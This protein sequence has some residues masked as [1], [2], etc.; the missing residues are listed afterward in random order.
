MKILQHLLCG[1]DQGRATLNKLDMEARDLPA[2]RDSEFYRNILTEIF[3][4][5]TSNYSSVLRLRHQSEHMCR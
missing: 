2:I 4:A 5:I 3:V 1:I